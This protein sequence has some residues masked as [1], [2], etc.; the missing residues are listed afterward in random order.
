VETLIYSELSAAQGRAA[1]FYDRSS[2]KMGENEKSHYRF[3][4]SGNSG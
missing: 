2:L 4:G 3:R 1:N